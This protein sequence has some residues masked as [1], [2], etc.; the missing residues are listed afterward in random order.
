MLPRFRFLLLVLA[1]V[2]LVAVPAQ[3]D[4][5]DSLKMGTPDLK[6]AGALAFGPDG[7]LF[8][9][10]AQG[11]AV[12]A[13]D[14]GD[15]GKGT[16][17]PVK[18]DGIDAKIAAL[19]GT[20]A[21]EIQINDLKVNPASGHVYLSVG[22]GRGPDAAPVIIRATAA[23]KLE[24]LPL[25][26]V[27]FAKVTLPNAK[28]GAVKGGQV[29]I[30]QLGF[31][32]GRVLVSGLSNEEWASTLRAIPFPFKDADKGAGIEIYHGAHGKFETHAPIRTFAAYEIAGQAHLL[33]AYTF[34]PLVKIPVADLT[35]G[36]KV[37]GTTVAELGNR[38]NPLDMIVYK[39]DNKDF[40]LMA[41]SSRGMMKINL[42]GVDKAQGIT[43]RIADKAGLPYDTIKDLA[44][45]M[46]MDRL[47]PDS[48]VVLIRGAE[49][50]LN[51]QT[52]PLP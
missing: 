49:G 30:T 29:A 16:P 44:G 13:I 38:N 25:K 42:E 19:L 39:K 37:K 27:K 36:A 2:A 6:S 5:T 52:V 18:V 51:L 8:V 3:G 45:V 43:S 26:N 31:V 47:N 7:I 48:A 15:R 35:A 21:K 22:R 24:Q 50:S 1:A 20:D 4:L 41:N 10:D 9:G 33:A 28:T 14:T 46:Q 17:A 40:V 11:A 32:D 34:T 12:F 23:G